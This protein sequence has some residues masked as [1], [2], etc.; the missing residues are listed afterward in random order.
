M[1][2]PR[3]P[4]VVV[5]GGISGLVA[6]RRLEQAGETVILIERADRL[7][8]VI[9]TES[10][11]GFLVERGPDGFVAGRGA[12]AEVA[13]ELGIADRIIPSHTLGTSIWWRGR[14]H[15]LPEGMML[16]A[17]TRLGP[18]ARTSLLSWRGKA[19]L[20]LDLVKPRRSGGGDES[21]QSFVLRR[22]GPEVLERI[23]QPL[24]AGIH[25]GRAE[26]MSMEASFPRLR[27]TERRH[28]SLILGARATSAAS[29]LSHFAS[30]RG[31]MSELTTALAD[32]LGQT[33]VRTGTGVSGL[34]TD[35]RF[36]LTLDSGEEVEAA[37]AVLAIPSSDASSLLSGL[38]PAGAEAMAEVVQVPTTAVTLGYR[39]EDLPR[40][41]GSGF[42]VPAVE[43]RHVTGVSYL[44]RKWDGRA[45]AGLEL[46][47]CFVDRRTV[48]GDPSALVRRELSELLGISAAPV[49]TRIDVL[50]QGLHRYQL[51]HIELIRRV[52]QSL[53]PGLTVAGSALYGIGINECII[54]GLRAAEDLLALRDRAGAT[55]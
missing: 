26:S 10:V 36:R 54:S 12:V 37:G 40:L 22:L 38:A 44:S 41:E 35:G 46:L 34:R 11:D 49:L 25:A 15:P 50:K 51:G 55:H 42:V 43:G 27:E 21:L 3:L 19:R 7:G 29:P 47:R 20:L 4:I 1:L 33:E 13:T 30:F 17:P 2:D 32:S 16:L 45:P 39:G 8:G 28:R 31:G 53:P 5:G 24:L 52:E 18:V 48:S 6:A 23:A 14:L 9:Q